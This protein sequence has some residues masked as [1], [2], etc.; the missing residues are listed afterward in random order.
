MY[1]VSQGTRPHTGLAIESQ[2][3]G[4]HPSG[5]RKGGDL[6]K[7]AAQNLVSGDHRPPP[8]TLPT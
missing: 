4:H 8:H 7:K 3:H 1:L 2:R 5:M 6:P